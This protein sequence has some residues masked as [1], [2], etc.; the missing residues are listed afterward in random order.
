[1]RPL[2]YTAKTQGRMKAIREVYR[3]DITQQEIATAI[4]VSK[5]TISGIYLRYREELADCP[6]RLPVGT[7]GAPRSKR[8]K[9]YLTWSPERLDRV[10]ELMQAGKTGKQIGDEF[11]VSRD[12]IIALSRKHPK[13]IDIGFARGR[14]NRPKL[15]EEQRIEN[16]RAARQRYIDKARASRPVAQT[17]LPERKPFKPVVV[18][19]N[20]ALMVQDFIARNGVRRFERNTRADYH[21]L[22]QYLE[23]RGYKLIQRATRYTLAGP[24]GRPRFVTWKEAIALV[25]KFRR[26]EGLEPILVAA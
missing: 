1:M 21:S 23:E 24:R 14:K 25:D 22:A 2:G 19:N 7:P 6:C 5:A 10:A 26:A 4:G 13:L 15:S 9:K 20:V 3:P 16:R 8:P 11:G 18:S 12:A 17:P